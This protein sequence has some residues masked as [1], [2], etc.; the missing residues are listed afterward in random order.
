MLH[1]CYN[2]EL[3]QFQKISA[4]LSKRELIEVIFMLFMVFY[5]NIHSTCFSWLLQLI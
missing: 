5:D 3:C 4:R 1:V 2:N